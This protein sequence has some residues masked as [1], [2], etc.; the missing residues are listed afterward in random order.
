M[1][2]WNVWTITRSF[3]RGSTW[4]KGGYETSLTHCICGIL[5]V[6]VV[7]L[8]YD[9]VAYYSR[10]IAMYDL[11]SMTRYDGMWY[12]ECM[13]EVGCLMW[14]LAW[15]RI[16]RFYSLRCTSIVWVVSM[17]GWY[18]VGLAH[19]AYFM[20]ILDLLG[21]KHVLIKMSSYTRIDDFLCIEVILSTCDVLTHIL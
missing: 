13:C 15:D 14:Y 16:M 1:N 6:V 5:R 3:L 17:L 7:M 2:E 21:K 4:C 11:H 12:Y 20:C 10:I 8:T 19:D 9:Y 18:H